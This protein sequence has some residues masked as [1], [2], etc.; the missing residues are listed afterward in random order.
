MP[1]FNVIHFIDYFILAGVIPGR[2]IISN[3]GDM[4]GSDPQHFV[5]VTGNRERWEI[6]D[7]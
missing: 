3:C 6:L 4:G 2:A 1:Y 5:P 7:F